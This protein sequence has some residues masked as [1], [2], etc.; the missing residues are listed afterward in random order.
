VGGRG[1]IRD[2]PM[3]GPQPILLKILKISGLSIFN[4]VIFNYINYIATWPDSWRFEGNCFDLFRKLDLGGPIGI[5][6]RQFPYAPGLKFYVPL[7]F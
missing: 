7:K 3:I 5:A 2:I 6:H 4:P 1:R